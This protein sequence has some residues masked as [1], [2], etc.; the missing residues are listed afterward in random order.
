MCLGRVLVH[1][2]ELLHH[3][4]PL[5]GITRLGVDVDQVLAEYV[6]FGLLLPLRFHDALR[7]RQLHLDGVGVHLCTKSDQLLEGVAGFGVGHQLVRAG[8]VNVEVPFQPQHLLRSSAGFFRLCLLLRLLELRDEPICLGISRTVV[9]VDDLLDV[10]GALLR[11]CRSCIL[12]RLAHRH[13]ALLLLLLLLV[14]IFLLRLLAL[15]LFLRLLLLWN[16][17]LLFLL[18]LLVLAGIAEAH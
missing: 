14:L 18:L 2:G 15:F 4:V 3:L 12:H 10:I 17:L 11:L 13:I 8:R 5:R 9:V 6:A 16:S 1:G 7:D